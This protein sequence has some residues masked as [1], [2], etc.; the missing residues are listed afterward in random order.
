MT[1]RSLGERRALPGLGHAR[2]DLS[3]CFVYL[4]ALGQ[5][6]TIQGLLSLGFHAPRAFKAA[7][8]S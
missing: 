3:L 1:E 4:L 5:K 6:A 2:L 8:P 7:M